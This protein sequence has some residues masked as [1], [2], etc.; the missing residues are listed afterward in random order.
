MNYMDRKALSK[1]ELCFSGPT[2]FLGIEPRASY[3]LGICC[4]TEQHLL[5]LTLSLKFAFIP[6]SPAFVRDKLYNHHC[7][8]GHGI[9]F[10]G[11]QQ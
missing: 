7:F 6:G 2:P 8:C 10:P 3:I 9:E 11:L 5:Q 1:I 4:T